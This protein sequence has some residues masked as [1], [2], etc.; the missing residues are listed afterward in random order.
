MGGEQLISYGNNAFSG[1]FT[2]VD[3]NGIPDPSL[4]SSLQYTANALEL[5]GGSSF[6]GTA[7][8]ATGAGNW[9]V[10]PW[11]PNTAPTKAGNT[12][13]LNNASSPLASVVLDVAGERSAR[14][15]W[16]IRDGSTTFGIQHL[17]RPGRNALTLDNSGSTSYIIVQGART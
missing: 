1:S 16:A 10:G 8:W 9:S 4:A 12:A 13:I 15:C 2:T 5:P 3:L 11:S 14:W 6:S 7:A 17:R